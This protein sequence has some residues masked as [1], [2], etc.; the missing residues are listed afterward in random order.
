MRAAL[1]LLCLLSLSRLA[2]AQTLIGVARIPA[3]AV[4]AEGDTLGGFGSGMMLAPGSW[5]Q[6]ETGY[7]AKL[8]ML[9]DRGWNTAGTND[10]QGR[11]QKFDMTLTPDRGN[12]GHEGQLNW[13][14][15]ARCS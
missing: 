8:F 2:Q 5:K 4:D 10:Y 9:P 14:S 12:P 3:N 15:W 11:L 1:V 7:Q 6:T 13:P